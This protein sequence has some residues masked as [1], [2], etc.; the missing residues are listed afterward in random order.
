[1]KLVDSNANKPGELWKALNAIKKRDNKDPSSNII[2]REWFYY[3]KKLMNM[4][5]HMYGYTPDFNI[6]LNSLTNKSI[7]K[8]QHIFNISLLMPSEPHDFLFFFKDLR[9]SQK[10]CTTD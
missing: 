3:F 7:L 2:Q 9:F 1:M 5:Y 10:I 6:T 4:N 8:L